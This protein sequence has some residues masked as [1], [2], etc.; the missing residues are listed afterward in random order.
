MPVTSKDV[1]GSARHC[2]TVQEREVIFS[3]FAGA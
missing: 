1:E 3:E 2:K